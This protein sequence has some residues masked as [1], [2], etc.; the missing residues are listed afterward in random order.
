MY[1]LFTVCCCET[2]LVS[3]TAL[4]ANYSLCHPSNGQWI[5]ATTVIQG[6]HSYRSSVHIHQ[7]F[8]TTEGIVLVLHKLAGL[9]DRQHK[10]PTNFIFCFCIGGKSSGIFGEPEPPSQAK[11]PTPPGGPTSNIFGLSDS[12]TTQSSSRGHPNKPK[13]PLRHFF[14]HKLAI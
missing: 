5:D 4:F 9:S 7:Q 1:V 12:A 3:L 2:V 13:V 14:S 11:R 10:P 8:V 6:E